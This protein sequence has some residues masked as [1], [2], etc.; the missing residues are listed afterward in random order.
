MTQDLT[1]HDSRPNSRIKLKDIPNFEQEFNLFEKAI[2]YKDLNKI[3]KEFNLDL[4]QFKSVNEEFY[5]PLIR[6]LSG[7]LTRDIA[8]DLNLTTME[9]SKFLIECK[10]EFKIAFYTQ[11]TPY[12]YPVLDEF[13]KWYNKKLELQ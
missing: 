13:Y 12:K 3:A 4:T 11:D 8:P 5:S 1:K 7:E 6:R 10:K 9:C 2:Y